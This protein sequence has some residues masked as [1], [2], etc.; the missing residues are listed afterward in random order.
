[1]YFFQFHKTCDFFL[2]DT[3][4]TMKSHDLKANHKKA[5]RSF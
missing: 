2:I 5:K 1:M 3:E 4:A